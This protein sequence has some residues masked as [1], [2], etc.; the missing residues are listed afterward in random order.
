[1]FNTAS[2]NEL[3]KSLDNKMLIVQC[4]QRLQ[5]DLTRETSSFLTKNSRLR[6]CFCS[7][8]SFTFAALSLTEKK[9]QIKPRL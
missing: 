1:M 8:F 2:E 9:L 5:G 4:G 7:H 3:T 6:I